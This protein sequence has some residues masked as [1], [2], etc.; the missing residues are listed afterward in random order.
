MV[1]GLRA[2]ATALARRVERS[3]ACIVEFTKTGWDHV[4]RTQHV[5]T[6]IPERFHFTAAG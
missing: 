1:C 2:L 4:Q 3:H 6:T 5:A